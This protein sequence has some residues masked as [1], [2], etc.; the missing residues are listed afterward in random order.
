[1]VSVYGI[2]SEFNPFHNGHKYLI[3]TARARGAEAVVCI[4]SGN[5]VQRGESAI[6]DKYIRAEMALAGGADLV[7]EL[8]YP[9]CASSAEFF[10]SCGVNI[11]SS[12]ADTLFFGSE[13]GDIDALSAAAEL[14]LE[15]GF[16]SEYRE[17][18]SGNAGTA[19]AYFEILE[20]R[21][22]YKYSSNDILGIEY[23]KA[24]RRQGS[25]IS[26]ETVGRLGASY[27]DGEIV[28][29]GM[30]SATAIRGLI[31]RGETER[32]SEYMPREC[33]E[34]LLAA[35]DK[36]ELTSRKNIIH[37]ERIFFRLHEPSDFEGIA[38][39]DEGLAARICACASDSFE[40]ELVDSLRTKRYTD[41]RLRRALLFC[42]TGVRRADIAAVPT[43]VN[44]LG[45]NS[46][47]R[48]LLSRKRKTAS[49]EVVAKQADA[50]NT[51]EARRQFSLS[52]KFDGIFS[53]SM[54]KSRNAAYLIKKSPVIKE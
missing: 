30:Q 33:V 29:G 12:F 43:Y 20:R 4:L 8:P 39:I 22:G 49:I 46:V 37:A 16:A 9:W 27:T 15:E 26:L 14:C 32:L 1:A 53:L 6:A 11:A 45:A 36:G 41:A 23:I 5:A 51:P 21:T 25:A 17:N 28:E 2:I 47:G 31:H 7:L 10:A 13:L 35:R 50:P 38:D 24:A 40:G 3:D 34:I 52:L 42:M 19:G 54:E 18:L 44:L 48:E